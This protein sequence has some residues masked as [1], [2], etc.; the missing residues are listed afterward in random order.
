MFLPTLPT[1]LMA[2]YYYRMINCISIDSSRQYLKTNKSIVEDSLKLVLCASLS[3]L[4]HNIN[5]CIKRY[6]HS[7]RHTSYVKT[8]YQHAHS[9]THTHAR[10]H[11]NTQFVHTFPAHSLTLPHIPVRTTNPGSHT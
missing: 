1:L 6:S 10:M 7:S 9:H 3:S 2:D 8:M 5:S 11:T 4:L